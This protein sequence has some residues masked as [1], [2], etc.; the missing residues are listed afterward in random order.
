MP[1][2]EPP[3][4]ETAVAG[5]VAVAVATGVIAL[6]KKKLTLRWSRRQALSESARLTL[7]R[8]EA[9]SKMQ[10]INERINFR[11][12]VDHALAESRR[13][14]EELFGK[15]RECETQRISDARALAR[16]EIALI[17]NGIDLN[18]DKQGTGVA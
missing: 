12:A 18:G 2:I 8:A 3:G 5:A 1:P 7:D 4:T 16:L 9:D 10:E 6:I 11:T 13:R 17:R 14:E 15:W